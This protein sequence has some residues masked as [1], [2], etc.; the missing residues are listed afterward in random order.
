MFITSFP[1]AVENWI[2]ILASL[3][4]AGSWFNSVF[5][6]CEAPTIICKGFR[7]KF[8]REVD[9]AGVG[10]IVPEWADV[11]SD[12][13]KFYQHAAALNDPLLF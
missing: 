2:L 10:Y 5:T 7:V 12:D 9:D 11:Q 13:K 3:I 4:S 8:N 6:V 1:S